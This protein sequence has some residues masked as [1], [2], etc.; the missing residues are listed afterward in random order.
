LWGYF[1]I[2]ALAQ[3]VCKKYNISFNELRS[4]SRRRDVVQ[5][6]GAISRVAVR[7]LGYSGADVAGI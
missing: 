4:G 3:Q 7:E 2:S 5:G 1:D 6:R